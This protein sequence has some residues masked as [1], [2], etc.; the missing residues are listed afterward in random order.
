MDFQFKIVPGS[1]PSMQS[2]PFSHFKNIRKN[3]NSHYIENHPLQ[4]I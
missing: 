2:I 1:Q 3:E 4:T